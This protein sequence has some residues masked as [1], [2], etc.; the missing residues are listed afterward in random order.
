M[1]RVRISVVANCQA[2]PL[3]KF[4]ALLSPSVDIVHTTITHLARDQDESEAGAAFAQSDFIFAQH[5]NDKY[6]TAFV[7][8]NRLR[9]QYGAKVVSWPNAFFRGQGP[10]IRYITKPGHGRVLGPLAEYQ[11]VPIYEAWRQDLSV[12][13]TL[14]M[15]REDDPEWTGGYLAEAED[16]LEELQRRE[17]FLDIKL[18]D[19]IAANWQMERLFFTFNHP[20]KKLLRLTA[21]RLLHHAEVAVDPKPALEKIR[22]PL[23]RI[24]PA[25]LPATA[26]ALGVQ[27]VTSELTTGSAMTIDDKVTVCKDSQVYDLRELVEVSFRCLDKQVSKDEVLKIS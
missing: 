16:S 6:P 7:A 21:E 2:R 13:D 15:L 18:T 23:D 17:R 11:N 5:V 8:T 4:L 1:A 10:D 19:F 12:Q 9:Q 3:A 20:S 22:E 24:I 14:R 27:L 25:F 26:R